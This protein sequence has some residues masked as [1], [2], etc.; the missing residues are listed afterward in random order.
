MRVNLNGADQAMIEKQDAEIESLQAENKRLKAGRLK[1]DK[2]IHDQRMNLRRLEETFDNHYGAYMKGST[3]LLFAKLLYAR[4]NK[5]TELQAVVDWKPINDAA[6]K[7]G[8]ILAKIKTDSNQLP[9]YIVVHWAQGGGED[10]PPFGPAWFYS[11]GHGFSELPRSMKLLEWRP[12]EYAQNAT[13]GG[14]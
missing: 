13:K 1:L 10:Q 6:K 3:R 4:Q 2:R 11:T 8:F 14:E 5:I 7:A 9:E 12:I